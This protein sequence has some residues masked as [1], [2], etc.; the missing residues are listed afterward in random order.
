MGLSLGRLALTGTYAGIGSRET[1]EHILAAMRAICKRL[2][3]LGFTL[4][5][6]GADGADT[7]C[8]EGAIEAKSPHN[9]FLPWPNFNKHHSPLDTV[10]D[11]AKEMGCYYHPRGKM[12]SPAQQKIMGRNC[13]QVL[14]RDLKTPVDFILCWT[15]GGKDVGG[16]GQALRIA[17]DRDIPIFNLFHS[18]ALDDLNKYLRL[19]GVKGLKL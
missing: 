3:E 2:G 5:T 6:G 13:Y 9:V 16:T 12:L 1:P 15:P 4:N 18:S 17:R 14:G 7:A 8:E 19:L 11:S 10:C